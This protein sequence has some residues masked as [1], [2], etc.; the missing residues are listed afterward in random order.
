MKPSTRT[1]SLRMIAVSFAAAG[2]I[3][4]GL[5]AQMAHGRD[6]ALGAGTTTAAGRSS[7]ANPSFQDQFSEQSDQS[8]A[9]PSGVVT[10][11]S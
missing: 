5:A 2:A 9:S 1:L 7:Q 3:F 4:A 6:P 10:R 11:A 8:T